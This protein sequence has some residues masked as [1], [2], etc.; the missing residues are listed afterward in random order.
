MEEKR[1]SRVLVL[2]NFKHELALPQVVQLDI[3][4]SRIISKV[5]R[6][7]WISLKTDYYDKENKSLHPID[8]NHCIG[9]TLSKDIPVLYA[10]MR[11]LAVTYYV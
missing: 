10:N 8:S 3:H 1:F 2:A 11:L 6:L 9:V 4:D 7:C 5:A